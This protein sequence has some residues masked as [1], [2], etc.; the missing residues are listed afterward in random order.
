MTAPKVHGWCP[1]ALRPMMSGDGLVVRLRA[2][3]GRLTQ[4]QAHGV[5]ALSKRFGNGGIDLSARANL[6]LRG[7]DEKGHPAL[8]AGLRDLGVIDRDIAAES[9]RNLVIQP[10]WQEGD[11]THQIVLALADALAAKDAPNLPGKFGFAIDCGPQ[12]VLSRVS[13]DIRIERGPDG[14]IC[15]ADGSR[16][17]M[18]VTRST[19]T[20]TALSLA[21]WFLRTGGAE[22]GRGRM[23]A[24]IGRHGLPG[25]ADQPSLRGPSDVTP[26]PGVTERGAALALEFGQMHADTLARIADLGPLRLTPWRMIL[27]EGQRV[28]PTLPGLITDPADPRLRVSVCTGAPGCNQ[29]RSAT[30]DIARTLAP[31]VHDRL[32]VS[33]CAKGCAHPRACAVTLTATAQGRF[34]LIR[35]GQA[36]DPPAHRDLSQADLL[37]R[38]L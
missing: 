17:G 24:H 20:E 26:G 23:S 12:P 37:S 2:P 28:L 18:A 10:F 22:G 8:I 3:M 32:H 1:G 29:A 11:D 9:R 27:I 25:D 38:E 35:N 16:T 15:R 31:Q 34:D 4:E 5:A 21:H 14:L 7:V 33:G 19:A 13:A 30:R 36:S 6:Q